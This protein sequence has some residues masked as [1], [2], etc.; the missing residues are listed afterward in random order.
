[1][2]GGLLNNELE[3]IW[4]EAAMVISQNVAG[5]DENTKILSG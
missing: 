4:K 5:T 2:V 1:M 3:R